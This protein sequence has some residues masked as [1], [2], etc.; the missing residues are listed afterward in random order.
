MDVKSINAEQDPLAELGWTVSL[1]PSHPNGR[2]RLVDGEGQPRGDPPIEGT[3]IRL[4]RVPYYISARLLHETG[5]ELLDQHVPPHPTLP[6][7][8]SV[9]DYTLRLML[10]GG[11]SVDVIHDGYFE[12]FVRDVTGPGQ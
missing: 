4:K 1:V 6:H 3:E 8:R 11:G 5:S 9:G 7:I 10:D 2:F 12:E